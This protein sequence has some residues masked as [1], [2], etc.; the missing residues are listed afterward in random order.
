MSQSSTAVPMSEQNAAGKNLAEKG[1]K[2]DPV[3]MKIESSSK[4]C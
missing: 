1:E 3:G 4:A 2:I